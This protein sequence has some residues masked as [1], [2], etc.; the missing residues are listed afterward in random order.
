VYEFMAEWN[1]KNFLTPYSLGPFL[2]IRK[3]RERERE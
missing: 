1:P 3:E 2:E